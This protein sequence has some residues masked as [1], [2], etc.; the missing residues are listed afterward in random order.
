M[1]VCVST[2]IFDLYSY[3][4]LFYFAIIFNSKSKFVLFHLKANFVNV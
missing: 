1:F 4:G 3:L 2:F